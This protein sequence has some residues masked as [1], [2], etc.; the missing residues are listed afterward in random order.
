MKEEGGG[1]MRGTGGKRS[2]V[3]VL[4]FCL[5]WALGN[6]L[7]CGAGPANAACGDGALDPGESCDDGNLASDDGCSAECRIEPRDH[8]MC[9]R[10][11]QAK[12]TATRA[13]SE[14]TLADRFESGE[15]KVG[16][17]V[18]FCRRADTNQRG[19]LD[20]GAH[21]TCYRI[22]PLREQRP[23]QQR[24]V[25]IGNELGGRILKA[26]RARMLCVHSVPLSGLFPIL[27]PC[28]DGKLDPGEE[29]DDGNT[30]DG[31]GCAANCRLEPSQRYLCHPAKPAAGSPPFFSQVV[32]VEDGITAGF[33]K[34]VK[35]VSLCAPAELDGG[36]VR[37]FNTHLECFKV[38]PAQGRQKPLKQKV[39][40]QSG[41]REDRFTVLEP[42]V[43]CVP[44]AVIVS[45]KIPSR[46]P[47]KCY[48]AKHLE[49][50]PRFEKRNV[51]LADRFE[52]KSMSV[53][54][55]TKI[56]NPA[57]VDA[58][59]LLDPTTHLTCYNINQ[60]AGQPRFKSREV[61]VYNAFGTQ[62]LTVE[63]PKFECVPSE[64][65]PVASST[66]VDRLKCYSAEVT[67]G[68]PPFDTRKVK[69]AD[70]FDETKRSVVGQP[71]L[72][73]TPV[74]Q[75]GKGFVDPS[76]DLTCFSIREAG[77]QPQFTKPTVRPRDE[78]GETALAV[79]EAETLCLPSITVFESEAQ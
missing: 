54:S 49:G 10:I 34:T 40:S 61:V 60:A 39:V 50:T 13:P 77:G 42:R 69:I 67:K 59:G 17:P 14:V 51:I 21:L 74:D 79:S 26:K 73:C 62:T 65:P 37:D 2:A 78:F 72:F 63:K 33:M 75:D 28:G 53:V 8:L 1:T 58:N 9:Y 27:I 48:S 36:G 55:P 46:D 71:A 57:D 16:K 32:S 47:V 15:A 68:A 35:P 64:I 3:A 20:S 45:P 12:G 44:S 18:M 19:I 41:F 38:R 23:R 43:L 6:G 24:T 29:C 5:S 70:R 11:R 4:L 22:P 31:D 7:L 25:L 30:V 76:A 66:A 56:C 52:T